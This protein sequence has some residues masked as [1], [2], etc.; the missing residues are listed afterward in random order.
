[1]SKLPKLYIIAGCNGAGKTTASFTILPKILGCKEF[2][3]ADEIAK[4]LSPFQPESV[5]VQAGRIMLARMDELL[6]KGA[7]FAFE[8]TLATKS[9]KQKIEWAQAND[10]EVTL[11]FFWLDS[12]NIAKK[13]VAQRVAEGGHNI[14]LETIERRYY[15]GIANLFTI[16]IDMV[17]IC[18]IFD[19]SEGERT[20]I[21]KKYKGEKE[22][23]Y[24]TDLYNQMKNSYE[25]ERS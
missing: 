25:K 21:A 9:Y 2:I 3:N 4:G 22:I 15:N 10:Y 19:N 11:L 13:R 5:A 18:Y 14:P 7:T 8:T 17:D 6:Q 16:Y 1:M 24:N 23:I 20:P 12:P